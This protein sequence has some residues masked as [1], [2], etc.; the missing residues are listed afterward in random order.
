MLDELR[1]EFEDHKELFKAAV[2]PLQVRALDDSA[3]FS[4]MNIVR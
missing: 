2:K 1:N 4:M 3:K